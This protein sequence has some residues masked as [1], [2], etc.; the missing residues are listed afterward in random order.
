M[1]DW[2]RRVSAAAGATWRY[3]RVNQNEFDPGLATLRRLL[4]RTVCDAMFTERDR[5]GTTLSRDEVRRGRD[6]GRM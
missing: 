3:A 2:C 1:R 5:R 6:A 4:V